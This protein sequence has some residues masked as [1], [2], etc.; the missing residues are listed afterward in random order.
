MQLAGINHTTSAAL[1]LITMLCAAGLLD[2][3]DTLA[4]A[5]NHG[6]EVVGLTLDEREEVLRV[7]DEPPDRLCDLRTV[8]LEEHRWRETVGL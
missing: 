2:T 4:T 1:E 7:L 5:W 8:L 3:A 6:D